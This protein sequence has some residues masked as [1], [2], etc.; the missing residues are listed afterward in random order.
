VDGEIAADGCVVKLYANL[1]PD[2]SPSTED[3][4]SKEQAEGLPL[5]SDSHRAGWSPILL[6]DNFILL[7]EVGNFLVFVVDRN[8]P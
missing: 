8:D 1:A 2:P 6:L 3:T 4:E 5:T 7:V